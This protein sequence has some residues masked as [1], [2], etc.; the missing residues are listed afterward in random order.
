[1]D[2]RV[3][4]AGD[5]R[6]KDAD[7]NIHARDRVPAFAPLVSRLIGKRTISRCPQS[8][9]CVIFA[10][11]QNSFNAATLGHKFSVSMS[12]SYHRGCA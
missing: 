6:G 7:S 9:L 4:P 2:P 8:E 5:D 3:T 12:R 10:T 1:M 11:L